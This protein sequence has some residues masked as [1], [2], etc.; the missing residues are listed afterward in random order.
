MS[1]PV[2]ADLSFER[3]GMDWQGAANTEARALQDRQEYLGMLAAQSHCGGWATTAR[4]IVGL[5][6]VL[7]GWNKIGEIAAS[8]QAAHESA[9][10]PKK[11]ENTK[12]RATPG[13]TELQHTR[14]ARGLWTRPA[15]TAGRWNLVPSLF[16]E[17]ALSLCYGKGIIRCSGLS[18]LLF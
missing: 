1:L 17:Q 3:F 15:Q 16:M 8:E 5:G 11:T 12:T 13:A 4:P 10:K 6:L 9:Q 18:L 7:P 14:H 2:S